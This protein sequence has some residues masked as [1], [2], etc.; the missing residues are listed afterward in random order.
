MARAKAKSKAAP[1]KRTR[2]PAGAAKRKPTQPTPARQPTTARVTDRS[3]AKRATSAAPPAKTKTKTKT[4]SKTKPKTTARRATPAPPPL[5]EKT[6]R[7]ATPRRPVKAA[8]AGTTRKQ[9]SVPRS[10]EP[11]LDAIP[12]EIDDARRLTLTARERMMRSSPVV[13]ILDDPHPI[14]AL[15][16]FLDSIKG[17]ATSQQAQIAL[18]SAQLML[19]PSE[20]DRGTPEVKEL[21]DL[22]FH[23]WED[24]GERK[25]GFHAQEFLRNALAAVGV[26]RERIKLLED[27]IPAHATAELLVNLAA[28]HAVARDKVAMMR[29]VEHALE[30]GASATD[31][32]R[33]ADFVPY[34]SDPDLAVLLARAEV[35]QIPVDIAPYLPGVR[36]ALDSLLTTLKEFGESVDLRPGVRIDAILDAERVGKVSLPNDYRALLTLTNGMRLWEH[37]FFAAGDYREPTKLSTRANQYLESSFGMTGIAECVPVANWGQP[38]DW[39]LYDPRGRL[40]G[41]EAGYVLV[42]DTN[43]E[44]VEDLA[45]ALVRMEHLAREVLGTN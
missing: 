33:H 30:A 10:A 8:K 29:A 42:L 4:K 9:T 12:I 13:E 27:L 36:A 31:F 3:A 23:H 44:P 41:G 24:F 19:L 7:R 37:E 21:V 38:K 22:V 40:R 15:R 16:R 20:H 5:N 34:T 17:E 45:A 25:K 28:A 18:G 1:A 32:R 14:G 35:P 2:V 39:L 11:L 43:E 26:D 6:A